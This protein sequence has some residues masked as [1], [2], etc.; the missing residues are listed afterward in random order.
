MKTIRRL[1]EIPQ[2]NMFAAE[3]IYRFFW[4]SWNQSLYVLFIVINTTKNGSN[5]L[6]LR[7]NND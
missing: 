1:R 4:P 5:V 7:I 6:Q 3:N 2:F